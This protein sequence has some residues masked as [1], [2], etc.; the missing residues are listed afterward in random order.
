MNISFSDKE[1]KKCANDDRKALRVMG[2]RRADL[3]KLRLTHLQDATTL[4]DVRHLP[5]NFHELT[6]TRKGTWACDLD[7][8]YRLIFKPQESPI[9]ENEDGQ[10]IWSEIKGIEVIEITNY[11]KEK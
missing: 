4:E 3:F 9:P 5:G 8:P 2:K 1:L 6:T 7:Q 10:Y 11:H